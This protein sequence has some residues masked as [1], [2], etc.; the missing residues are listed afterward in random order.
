MALAY[1][2]LRAGSLVTPQ[3]VLAAAIPLGVAALGYSS[4]A[5]LFG[6]FGC[7]L[8]ALLT[9]DARALSLPARRG[10]A[11]TLVLAGLLAGVVYYFHYIPGFWRGADTVSSQP[12]LFTGNTFWI[13]RNESKQSLRVWRLGYWLWL[14]VG[15]AAAP[16]ALARARPESRP[17]LTAWLGAWILIIVLKDPFFFPRMLRWAKENQFLSP[18][19]CLLIGAAAWSWPSGWM[20][21]LAAAVAL[22]TAA[23]LQL[24]DF[25][26]H[27]NSLL[28]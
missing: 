9:L 26:L 2:A 8:L 20:R 11:L 18:L 19:L 21:W 12:D 4:Y 27:A 23:W 13:F 5:A 3:A 16:V 17:V 10:L 25:Q 14:L 15:L 7:V 24:R 28:L 1:L 22:L 6:L